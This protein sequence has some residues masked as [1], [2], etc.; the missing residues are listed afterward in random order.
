ML[1][2]LNSENEW[3][4]ITNRV[5]TTVK[6]NILAQWNTTGLT[7]NSYSIKL[8]L[9][10]NSIDSNKV[11]A[12]KSINILPEV[13]TVENMNRSDNVFYY[14]DNCKSIIVDDQLLNK[15]LKIYNSFGQI[16]K[17]IKIQEKYTK[18]KKEKNE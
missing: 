6:D 14:N 7:P 9:C 17:T 10:D 5:N 18:L 1:Y 3:T 16:V 15:T 12:I 13:L 4:P 8:V 11:E 2:K